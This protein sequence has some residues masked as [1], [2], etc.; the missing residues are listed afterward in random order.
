VGVATFD[1]R[2]PISPDDLIAEADR[3]MYEHKR[4]KRGDQLVS[5]PVE[6]RGGVMPAIPVDR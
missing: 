1:P 6:R 4:S 3:R 2:R 5:A